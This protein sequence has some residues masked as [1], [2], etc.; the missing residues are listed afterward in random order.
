M[1][2]RT[3]KHVYHMIVTMMIVMVT[4]FA[5]FPLSAGADD[6][7]YRVDK[8]E[9]RVLLEENGSAKIIESWTVTFE[10]G[11]FTRFS[12]DIYNPNNQLEYI[13]ELHVGKARINGVDAVY[14]K[15]MD[16]IDGHYTVQMES[17]RYSINW[18]QSAQNETVTYEIGYVIDNAVKLDENN[19]ASFC[20]RFIGEN[21]PESVGN[22][23]ATIV[24][25]KKDNTVNYNLSD[26][27]GKVKGTDLIFNTKNHYGMYKVRL[28]MSPEGFGDLKRVIDVKV[29]GSVTRSSGDD[30]GTSVIFIVFFGIVAFFVIGSTPA[31]LLSKK[32]V[33][34][35][36]IKDPLCFKDSAKRIDSY[37]IPYA[38]YLLKP[39]IKRSSI[40]T[41]GTLF[42]VEIFDLCNKG[43]LSVT[44]EGLKV[45]TS[46]GSG[47]WDK[48]Q[49]NMDRS[50]I[51]MVCRNFVVSYD[52]DGRMIPFSGIESKLSKQ[53]YD[54]TIFNEMIK[55]AKEYESQIKTS[56]LYMQLESEGRLEPLKN[57]LNFWH[58]N[59]AYA[60]YNIEA[61]DCISTILRTGNIDNFTVLMMIYSR[62]ARRVSSSHPDDSMNT[63]VCYIDSCMHTSA[64]DSSSGYSGG[65][66]SSCS[67][68]SSCSGCGGGGA[69]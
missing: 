36:L 19:R 62:M 59:G 42:F 31:A 27:E 67:S 11:S 30:L 61:Y 29:P 51:D 57:D 63:F 33:S 38:W 44:S 7:E 69:D 3:I 50:F 49:V 26:G 55:W 4:A 16:R 8:V 25:P 48:L 58:K 43:L 35:M 14:Q 34:R 18:F 52:L 32:R 13:K 54:H 40:Q 53:S 39:F 66:C 45:N 17:D 22:V 10:K 56:T 15:N 68:C 20:Y 46:S 12:K 41:Y 6:K 37:N 23:T 21:F 47:S 9:F 64:R 65:G 28:D 1:K 24:M 5:A 2:N 60:D